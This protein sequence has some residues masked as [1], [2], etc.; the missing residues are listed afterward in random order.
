MQCF[1]SLDLSPQKYAEYK[2]LELE[3]EL[4]DM[5]YGTRTKEN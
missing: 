3:Q 1:G 4:K 5:I 2:A